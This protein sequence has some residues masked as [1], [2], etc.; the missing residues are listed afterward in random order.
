MARVPRRIPPHAVEQ[1]PKWTDPLGRDYYPGDEVIVPVCPSNTPHAIVGV[2]LAINKTDEEG[3]PILT[4]YWVQGNKIHQAHFEPSC[5]VTI[6]GSLHT[7]PLAVVGREMTF[8]R[9]E[10]IFLLRSNTDQA[11]LRKASIEAIR[12]DILSIVQNL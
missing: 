12:Q 8:H 2:V 4:H 11:S 6:R 9:P 7:S 3:V 5:S 1:W 10:I